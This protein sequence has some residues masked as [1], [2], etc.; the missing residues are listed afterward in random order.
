MRKKQACI[1]I[2]KESEWLS[3]MAEYQNGGGK[4]SIPTV[5]PTV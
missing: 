5:I 2:G 4:N 3:P 1:L